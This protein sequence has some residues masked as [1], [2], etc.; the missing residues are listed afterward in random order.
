MSAVARIGKGLS[1]GGGSNATLGQNFF[2][3]GFHPC[4]TLID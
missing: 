2:S 1:K 4:L 3:S